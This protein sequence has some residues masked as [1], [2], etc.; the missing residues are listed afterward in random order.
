VAILHT[1]E[2]NAV[3]G[4]VDKALIDALPSSVKWIAHKGAG[5]DDVDVSACKAKG[6][7]V[8]NTPKAVDEGT[9]T[10]A[11]YLLIA[12]VRNFTLSE[13]SLRA[14]K[15]KPKIVESTSYD[16]STRTLGVL[17]LGGIGTLLAEMVRPM[18]M[19]V[20]YHNRKRSSEAPDFCEYF[21]DLD[22]MLAQTDV[23]SVHIPLSP[24]TEHFVNDKVIR[25]MKKG[26]ILINTARGK[27]VDEE[28]MIRALEDGHLAAIG[29]DVYPEEPKVNPRLLEFPTATLLPHVGTETQDSRRA[30]EAR[31]IDN[32]HDFLTKGTGE[33]LVPE[34]R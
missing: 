12:T 26:S 7:N 2:S 32:L 25:K 9:A 27:V 18:N 31:C 24:Q 1:F 11:L 4:N 6:I 34:C 10:T 17:G 30:M 23:L 5:Y 21:E 22:E 16:L 15:W 28:A 3:Y 20:I 33:N 13:A 19:R 8:S 14:G 29:L